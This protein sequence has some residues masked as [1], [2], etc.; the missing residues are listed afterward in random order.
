MTTQSIKYPA[1]RFWNRISQK[2]AAQK[3][4]DPD[5]YQ[6]KLDTTAEYMTPEMSVLEFGCGTGT[7]ALI[8]APRVARIDAIDFSPAMIDIARGKAEGVSNVFFETS[9]LDD[10]PVPE[11]RYDMV[12]GHSILH[13]VPDLEATLSRVHAMLKPGGIFVSSTVCVREMGRIWPVLLPI[14][15]KLG[16]IPRVTCLAIADLRQKLAGA[17]FEEIEFRQPSEKGTAFIIAR[18]V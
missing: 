5:A 12:M 10:W 15:G 7:T 3:V 1:A 11:P 2:Y 4:S 17:G 14:G 18:A 9:T 13:L 16:V 8:H 6:R